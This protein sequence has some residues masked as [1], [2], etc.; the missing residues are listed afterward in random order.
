MHF[1]IVMKKPGEKCSQPINHKKFWGQIEDI[2]LDV[3]LGFEN[4]PGWGRFILAP[5]TENLL[6]P[7]QDIEP[8]IGL[9]F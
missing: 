6:N 1:I 4:E 2:D 7:R 8:E 5:L 3:T 9:V